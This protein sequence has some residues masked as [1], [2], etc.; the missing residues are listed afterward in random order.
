MQS[1]KNIFFSFENCKMKKIMVSIIKLLI[2]NQN[3]SDKFGI[4]DIYNQNH[5]D[6]FGISDDARSNDGPQ[7]KRFEGATSGSRTITLIPFG[8][9]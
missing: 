3:H 5:C 1:K 4:S 2:Y 7:P 9:I 6:K 8:Q